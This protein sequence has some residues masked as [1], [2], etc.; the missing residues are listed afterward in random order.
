MTEYWKTQLH[1]G[2]RATRYYKHIV[3]LKPEAIRNFANC[4]SG[5]F[6]AV[7]LLIVERLKAEKLAT[8]NMNFLLIFMPI[9]CCLSLAF[10]YVTKA[11]A[12]SRT[13]SPVANLKP[14][15]RLFNGSATGRPSKS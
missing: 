7:V 10:M 13:P 6:S 3:Y 1:T 12:C 5:P 11:G 14:R 4:G 8:E 2:F 9:Y 15:L